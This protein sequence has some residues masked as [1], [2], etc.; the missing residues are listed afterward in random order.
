MIS[1]LVDGNNNNNNDDNDSNDNHDN[2]IDDISMS[3]Y[4]SIHTFNLYAYPDHLIH[5]PKYDLINH[6]IH[7]LIPILGASPRLKSKFLSVQEVQERCLFV[8]SAWNPTD[9]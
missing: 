6:L 1:V 8:N 5:H 9:L 3:I 2:N 7:H 4:L